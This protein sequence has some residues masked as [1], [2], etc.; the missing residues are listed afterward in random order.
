MKRAAIFPNERPWH[1]RAL[2]TAGLQRAGFQVEPRLFDPR[3]GDVLV[4][5]NRNIYEEAHAQRFESAGATV[6]IAENGYI[7][8][9][10]SG[11]RPL[12]LAKRYHNGAG[13]W[14]IGPTSRW[15][16]DLKPWRDRG[17]FILLLPQRGI[18]P[19]GVAMPNGWANRAAAELKK[20]TG[21]PIK[22]RLHPGGS[23]EEPYE[24][25]KGAW[26]AV[27]WGSGAAIKALFAGVPVFYDFRSWIGAS[28]AIHL[29]S[30]DLEQPF[31]GDRLP[32]FQRLAWAQWSGREIESGEAFAFLLES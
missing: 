7:G 8:M 14:R 2:F 12:A 24:A 18:G 1:R 13:Q 22:L 31:T 6:V 26:A 16:M 15:T 9:D 19:P 4:L 28:A 3:P 23:K 30:A 5:W 21:R 20:M 27:T 11:G 32:M 29:K 10:E 17:D 25:L